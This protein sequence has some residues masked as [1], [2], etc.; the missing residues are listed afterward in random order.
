M[1]LQLA[2][3]SKDHPMRRQHRESRILRRHDQREHAIGRPSRILQRIGARRFVAVMAVGDV[4]RGIGKR[5]TGHVTHDPQPDSDTIQF[6]CRV[7]CA[8]RSVRHG[9]R[10]RTV[11]I[12]RQQ[13]DRFDVGGCR[14][15]ECQ[16]IGLRPGVRPLVRPH[17]ARFIAFRGDGAEEAAP[18]EFFSG[19]Q[20][21]VL[22]EH[23]EHR[24]LIAPQH[25]FAAPCRQSFGGDAVARFVGLAGRRFRQHDVHDILCGERRV[26]RALRL[27]DDVVRRRDQRAEAVDGGVPLTL[28]GRD[29]VRHELS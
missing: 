8:L 6:R 24:L 22:R 25:S 21:K 18:S 13:E 2:P 10:Q 12:G 15:H 20:R 3:R 11:T 4:E 26:P 7:G 28:K 29:E 5:E 17:A 19:R 14:A 27:I 1:P 9:V 23:V 16:T